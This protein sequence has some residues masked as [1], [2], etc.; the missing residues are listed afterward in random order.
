MRPWIIAPL[1]LALVTAACGSTDEQRAASGGLGGA[2]AGA[3]VGGPVGA[4]VGAGV[5]AAGGL[6]R[7]D[8]EQALQER[9]GQRQT[10]TSGQTM[11]SA[12]QTPASRQASR[13]MVNDL[14]NADVRQAQTAL[15]DMGLY[16]GQVDGLYGP[17]TIRAVSEFQ[18]HNDMAAT[19]ELTDDTL[20][21]L[22]QTA[23]AGTGTSQEQNGQTATQ[24][25]DQAPVPAEQPQTGQ[26]TATEPAST[27]EQTGTLPQSTTP[28]DADDTD[29]GTTTGTTGGTVQ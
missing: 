6:V 2:A 13:P 20:D 18:R 21:R 26:D 9:Q 3:V 11:Q 28:G 24:P 8:A 10:A 5:G 19:G 14:D 12:A 29:P 7:D 25:A 17:R 16:D 1:G 22:T 15:R 23:A 27:G 4:A